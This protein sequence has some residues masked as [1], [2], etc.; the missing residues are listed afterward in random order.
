MT[1]TRDRIARF[2]MIVLAISTLGAFANAALGIS[3]VSPD[4]I[5]I[6][7]WRMFAFLVFAGLFTQLA[8]LPRRMPGL[9]ELVFFQ[10]AGV[11]LFVAYA[12]KSQAGLSLADAGLVPVDTTLAATTFVCYVLARGWRAWLPQR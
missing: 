1:S 3:T 12:A 4:R 10:K 9:W 5:N 2:L 8:F 7:A 6:E 11:A